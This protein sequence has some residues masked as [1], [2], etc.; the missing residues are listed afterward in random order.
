MDSNFGLAM[1]RRAAD[2]WMLDVEK[3]HRSA[4]VVFL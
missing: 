3:F 4:A 2:I 1:G